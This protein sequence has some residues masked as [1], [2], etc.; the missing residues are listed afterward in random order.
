ML[1][2]A[3]G[4]RAIEAAEAGEPTQEKAGADAGLTFSRVSRA[5][6]QTVALEAR[7]SDKL[8]VLDEAPAGGVVDEGMAGAAERVR[9]RVQRILESKAWESG[10]EGQAAERLGLKP[11]L[12]LWWVRLDLRRRF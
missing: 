3:L 4:E 12:L 2:R 10:A 8:R 9:E 6:R 7:L 5:V 1:A 11:S